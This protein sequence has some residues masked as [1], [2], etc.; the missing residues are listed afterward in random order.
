MSRNDQNLIE[1]AHRFHSTE[2]DLIDE[3]IEQAESDSTRERLKSIQR[4]KYHREELS[5]GCL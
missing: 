2:W 5:C 3:L 4:Q 1:K